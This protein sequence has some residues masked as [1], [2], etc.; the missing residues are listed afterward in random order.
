MVDEVCHIVT[1]KESRKSM[2]TRGI[3]GYYDLLMT[4]ESLEGAFSTKESEKK[5][6]TASPAVQSNMTHYD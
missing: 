5:L 2:T 4:N 6:M 1:S 3:A